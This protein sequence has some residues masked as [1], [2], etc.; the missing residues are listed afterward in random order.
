VLGADNNALTN[1]KVSISRPDGVIEDPI[2]TQAGKITY[3]VKYAGTYKLKADAPLYAQAKDEFIAYNNFKVIVTGSLVP[4][5]DI[6]ATVQDMD[7]KP[8]YGA[9]VS[10]KGTSVSGSTDSTGKY[11]FSL[12]EPK[13]YTITVKKDSFKDVTQTITIKGTLSLRISSREL[14]VGDKLE[15]VL[16]DS[17]GNSVTATLKVMEP[18]GEEESVTD[19]FKP[20][21]PGA[22][23]LTATKP[24]YDSASDSFTVTQYQLTLKSNIDSGKIVVTAT[25][26]DSPVPNL[27]VSFDAGS[28]HDEVKTDNNGKASIGVKNISGNVTISATD[29]S[30]EKTTV[31]QELKPNTENSSMLLI[32]L[33]ALVIIVIAILAFTTRGQGKNRKEKGMLY[34]T[35]GSHLDGRY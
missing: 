33:A 5:A 2:T 7:G 32:I 24:G 30:Y 4:G 23:T 14:K 34:R 1:A 17:Q 20:E 22:Y 28:F 21:Q 3:N 25:S 18:S 19:S 12:T 11:T 8:V 16:K 6:T 27:T 13:D 26:Q 31:V 35:A 9:A 10:V 29:P 15:W